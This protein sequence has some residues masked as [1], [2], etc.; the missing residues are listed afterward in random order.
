MEKK[1]ILTHY[2]K[3]ILHE[4]MDFDVRDKLLG[5]C[6]ENEK[7]WDEHGRIQKFDDTFWWG[8]STSCQQSG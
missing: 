7:D 4:E 3:E 2:K 8:E 6:E 1:Y 5:D